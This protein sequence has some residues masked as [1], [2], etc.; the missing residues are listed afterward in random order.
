MYEL[1]YEPLII[2]KSLKPW[3]ISVIP[4]DTE[5]F[6][7]GVSTLKPCNDIDDY[8][9]DTLIK[10]LRAYSED[11]KIHLITASIPAKQFRAGLILQKAG[12]HMIDIALSVRYESRTD[13]SE[14]KSQTLYLAPA[15]PDEMDTLVEI[16]AVSFQHGRYHL[17]PHFPRALA[18]KRY[19]EWVTRCLEP[20]NPQQVLTAKTDNTICGFSVVEYKNSEGY[21]HLNAIDTQWQGKKL[22]SK[23]IAQSLH[24]LENLGA[25]SVSTKISASNL[26]AINM[27][28]RLN[29]HFTAAE[30]LLHWHHK[31]T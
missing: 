23:M 22:G 13:F 3:E 10:A 14:E 24:Y 6:G 20:Q 28:A 27:H 25:K 5:T 29:G 21:L 7:F 16:A 30:Y 15:T 26:S 19:R 1:Q 11:K 4:W 12:F 31:E 17:D 2:N 18:D 9:S 8:D